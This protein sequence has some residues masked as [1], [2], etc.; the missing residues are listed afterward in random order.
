MNARDDTFEIWQA[1][2]NTDETFLEGR[3]VNYVLDRIQ[4]SVDVGNVLQGITDPDS[5][6]SLAE[7][8]YRTRQQSEKSALFRPFIVEQYLFPRT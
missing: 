8:C 7:R 4:P 6:Q 2:R 3:I 5:E 1:F